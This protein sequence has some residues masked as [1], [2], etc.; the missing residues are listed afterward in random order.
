MSRS[1][2]VQ[3]DNVETLTSNKS[4]YSNEFRAIKF[5]ARGKLT[6]YRLHRQGVKALKGY[7]RL[8]KWLVSVMPEAELNKFFIR[9]VTPSGRD[10]KPPYIREVKTDDVGRVYDRLKGKFFPVGMKTLT[11]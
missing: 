2:V 11:P 9:V 4:E 10:Y 1:E 8:R 5:R 6:T 3:I 7:L